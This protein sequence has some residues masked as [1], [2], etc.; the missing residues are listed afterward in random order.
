MDVNWAVMPAI[1]FV[2]KRLLTALGH[3]GIDPKRLSE[4]DGEGKSKSCEYIWKML[5]NCN[6]AELT[7]AN[8]KLTEENAKNVSLIADLR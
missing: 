4:S 7:E 5:K 3:E 2:G 6:C 8:A 1:A